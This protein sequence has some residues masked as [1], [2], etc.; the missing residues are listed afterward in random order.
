[1]A[2]KRKSTGKRLRF[3]VFKRDHFTCQYCGAQP[4]DVV[5][6]ADHI[7]PVAAGGGNEIENLITAC[8]ACNQGKAHKPLTEKTIRP[9]ADLMYL[10]TQ[11]EIAER[12]AAQASVAEQLESTWHTYANSVIDWQPARSITLSLITKYGPEITEEAYQDVARKISTGYISTYG[13]KWL[14]YL[15]A[16]ARNRY[17][18]QYAGQEA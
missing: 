15:Y 11:Q 10:E 3:E 6:V 13:D 5:L 18:D 16:V 8:E 7:T 1:M 2:G 14:R 17:I 12:D 9:D 4:P